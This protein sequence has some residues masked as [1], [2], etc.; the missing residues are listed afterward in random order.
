MEDQAKQ[1]M[2]KLQ[3]DKISMKYKADA[4]EKSRAE[5]EA[6]VRTILTLYSLYSLYS[7]RRR[8]RRS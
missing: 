3:Q 2:D 8:K 1:E 7:L 5:E 4:A 6:K